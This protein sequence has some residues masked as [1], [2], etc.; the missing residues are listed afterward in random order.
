MITPRTP[1][2]T[3]AAAAL[4]ILLAGSPASALIA[5]ATGSFGFEAYDFFINN[6]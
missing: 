2:M 3:L 5:P 6:I 4:L 1:L